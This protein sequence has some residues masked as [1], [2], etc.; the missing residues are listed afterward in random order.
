MPQRGGQVPFD[1]CHQGL[2]GT[3]HD[4]SSVRE[5]AQL[6]RRRE[7]VHPTARR[8]FLAACRRLDEVATDSAHVPQWR[9]PL[10]ADDPPMTP[11]DAYR[12]HSFHVASE[13]LRA[14]AMLRAR[15]APS[16]RRVRAD[17]RHAADLRPCA[18]ER[19]RSQRVGRMEA[20]SSHR[21]RAPWRSPRFSGPAS[22]I[23][24]VLRGPAPTRVP[25]RIASVPAG[26]RLGP[27]DLSAGRTPAGR[28]SSRRMP[29]GVF[30]WFSEGDPI[31]W[32][33]PDP[34]M[35]LFPAGTARREVTR[36]APEERRLPRH[37]GHGVR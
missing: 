17:R 8:P 19:R 1:H 26:P 30:P 28:R 31:L 4:A 3:R 35:V 21:P 24:A 12:T 16:E 37:R 7:P 20:Q 18:P 33:S 14:N 11:V 10:D 22:H 36:Q 9:R 13:A 34:R 29:R 15:L 5:M 27:R 25:V 6:F 2:P 23:D 32:W